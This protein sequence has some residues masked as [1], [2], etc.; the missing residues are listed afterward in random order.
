MEQ[1][2]AEETTRRLCY[3]CGQA[4]DTREHVVPRCFYPI[5]PN[6]PLVTVP[7]C[8]SCNEALSKDEEYLRA[9]MVAS[10]SSSRAAQVVWQ[11]K[12][13]PSFQRDTWDGL[14]KQLAS[15]MREV[16]LPGPGGYLPHGLVKLDGARMDKVAEKI[17]RGLYCHV[18]GRIMP[19]DA[20]MR[21]HWRPK[22]WLPEFALRAE[23]INI[24][25][26]V[27]SC[28][29]KIA[30][31]SPRGISIWWMLFYRTI[32][33]VVTARHELAVQEAVGVV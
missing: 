5:K 10:A 27:F 8:R 16:F 24:D 17:V 33:Y 32:L 6:A 11:Q 1:M 30:A 19:Q 9:V 26:D 4:A 7:A 3:R 29:Y 14:R 2:S 20:E 28:R 22:D 15:G 31:G 25:P 21:L 18:T 12:V 23:L 13:A